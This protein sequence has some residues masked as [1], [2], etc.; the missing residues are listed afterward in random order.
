MRSNEKESGIRNPE[1]RRANLLESMRSERF[2]SIT[3]L[4]K[5]TGIPTAT[6]HR[7]L[8]LL[9]EKGQIKK[10]YGGVEVLP[11]RGVVREYD[12]RITLAVDEKKTIGKRACSFVKPGDVIFVD[13]SSTS[14]YFCSQLMESP[15][16]DVTVITNSVHLPAEFAGNDSP[17]R[18]IST[19]G[20]ID[21][22]LQAFT[23]NIAVSCIKNFTIAKA[24]ISAAGFSLAAGLTTT[25]ES[26]HGVLAAA[27]ASSAA[28][29]YC[30]VDSSKFGKEFVF[31]IASATDFT[32]VITDSGISG[33]IKDDARKNQIKLVVAEA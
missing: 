29:R 30:L 3:D 18:M 33:E 5:K 13:A 20:I 25:A 4:A 10:T 2:H 1:L 23:G 26:L 19:G 9:A 31:R 27:I 32:A 12:K 24:F 28:E 22:D 6:L 16:A 15:P 8:D 17:V 14:Y 7:D 11:A 21:R